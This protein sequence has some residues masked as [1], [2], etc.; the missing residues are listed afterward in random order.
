[1]VVKEKCGEGG[2]L[3]GSVTSKEI[4]EAIMKQHGIEIDKK[5]IVLEEH[6][7]ELGEVT[8]QVKLHAGISTDIVVS[9]EAAE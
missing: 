8:L 2:R 3:F 5:R 1:V 7:K 9:V 6:I 4:S